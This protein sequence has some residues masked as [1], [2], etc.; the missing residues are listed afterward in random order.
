MLR[1]CALLRCYLLGV[2]LCHMTTDNAAAYGSD[3]SV[4]V[5]IVT[6]YAAHGSTL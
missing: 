3:D 1:G 2:L 4:V 5:G 6:R